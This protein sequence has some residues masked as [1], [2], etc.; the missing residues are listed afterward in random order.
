MGPPLSAEECLQLQAHT[1]GWI[2]GLQLAAFSLSHHDDRAGFIA[3]FSGSHHY[4]MEVLR[5]GLQQAAPTLVPHLH[6]RASRWYKQHGFFSEAVS[7]ALGASA[8]AEAARL[9]EQR[10]WTFFVLGNQMQTLCG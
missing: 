4:A 9:I 7:H 8:F 6:L 2:T 5:Q 3:A 1:E 10:L